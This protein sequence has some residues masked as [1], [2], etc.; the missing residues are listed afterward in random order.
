[1]GKECLQN[2]E[3]YSLGAKCLSY[4]P[5]DQKCIL[6][7]PTEGNKETRVCNQ[8]PSR[9]SWCESIHHG[10]LVANSMV[11]AGSRKMC[12][13][14]SV[15]CQKP[16]PRRPPWSTEYGRKGH[17]R[18][19]IDTWVLS[20]F[21]PSAHMKKKS[22]WHLETAIGNITYDIRMSTRADIR[23]FTA[24]VKTFCSVSIGCS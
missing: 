10:W 21:L 2:L 8:G 3:R 1:M 6:V 17:N 24:L 4:T 18:Q 19:E 12:R 11:E 5:V 14:P 7:I 20:F 15:S 23:L 9:V 13:L 16:M 22:D